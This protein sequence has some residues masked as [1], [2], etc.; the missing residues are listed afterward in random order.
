PTG[1]PW[2]RSCRKWMP[3]TTRPPATS[4]QGMIRLSSTRPLLVCETHEVTQQPQ[5]RRPTSLRM[6][7]HAYQRVD[8]DRADK[9]H[10]VDRLAGNDGSVLGRDDVRMRE[11]HRLPLEPRG[12]RMRCHRVEGVP[13]DVR[14]L[15]GRLEV[16]DR[17]RED[18][19]AG[20]AIFGAPLEEELKAEADAQ[21]RRAAAN[22]VDQRSIHAP[23][24]KRGHRRG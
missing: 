1:S 19:Q 12:D 22:R 16:I 5:P 3:F 8:G 11:V 7:L 20:G 24:S 17:S 10:A 23:A 6:E 21:K 18:A 15:L 9:R 14:E 2:S 4:R 13:T